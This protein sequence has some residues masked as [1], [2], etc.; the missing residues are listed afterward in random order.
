MTTHATSKRISGEW[1]HGQ[2]GQ[3]LAIAHP[4]FILEVW[5]GTCSKEYNSQGLE[6]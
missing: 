5:L 6:R 2:Q 3:D 1:S 4:S